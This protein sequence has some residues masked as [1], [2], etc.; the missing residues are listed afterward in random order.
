[1]HRTRFEQ[2]YAPLYQPPYNMGTTIWSPLASGLLTGKYNNSV[3][4]GSRLTQ[5]GYGWLAKR[6]DQWRSE[7]KIDQVRALTKVAEEELDCTVSQLALAWCLRNKNVS[8]ILLGATKASQLQENLVALQVVG[9]ITDE[10][11][12]KIEGILGN[13]PS[14]YTGYGGAGMRSLDTL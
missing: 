13:K 10:I 1:M 14:A 5:D 3:P 9:R 11:A 4:E 2:E 7:G 8:T 12:E 6:L